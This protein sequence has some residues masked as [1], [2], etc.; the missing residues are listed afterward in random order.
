MM[1]IFS[2]LSAGHVTE[3]Y[4]QEQHVTDHIIE[5]HDP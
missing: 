5:N 2:E 1:L 3:D 4:I